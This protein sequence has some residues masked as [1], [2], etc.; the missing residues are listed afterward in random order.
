MNCEGAFPLFR[1]LS[2][3][4]RRNSTGGS[5]F[6]FCIATNP[7][8]FKVFRIVDDTSSLVFKVGIVSYKYA[9]LVNAPKCNEPVIVLFDVVNLKQRDLQ[10]CLP[11]RRDDFFNQT[12][13]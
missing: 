2:L 3:S 6:F 5:S 4:L 7:L 13:L 9:R 11:F 10:S 12:L 1:P 8:E